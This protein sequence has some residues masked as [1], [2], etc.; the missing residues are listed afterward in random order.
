MEN[1]NKEKKHLMPAGTYY[2][3][4]PC[5][6][7]NGPTGDEWWNKLCDL[8]FRPMYHGLLE[9]DRI[10]VW[11]DSTN[12]GDGSYSSNKDREY[13]VDSGT[14]GIVRIDNVQNHTAIDWDAVANPK[15]YFNIKVFAEDFIVR[16]VRDEDCDCKFF[17]VDDEVIET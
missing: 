5:Y 6:L 12:F 7:F 4:D 10:T 15:H 1:N 16:T 11:S 17:F 8:M 2:I 9:V 14:I 3:G 13:F